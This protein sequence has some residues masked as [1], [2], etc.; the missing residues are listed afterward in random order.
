[1]LCWRFKHPNLSKPQVVPLICPLGFWINFEEI[2]KR[3]VNP[4]YGKIEREKRARKCTTERIRN[5][6]CHF[7]G[8]KIHLLG[9][10]ENNSPVVQFLALILLVAAA[11]KISKK[12]TGTENGF[13]KSKSGTE[14]NSPAYIYIYTLLYAVRAVS[15]P[16]FGS[17]NAQFLAQCF[18]DF[19]AYPNTGGIQFFLGRGGGKKLILNEQFLVQFSF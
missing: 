1:M 4:K 5:C 10:T 7:W 2:Q 19:F 11:I 16:I 3:T 17:L 8:A 12:N 6:T 18:L 14:N 9:G 15:G 13:P